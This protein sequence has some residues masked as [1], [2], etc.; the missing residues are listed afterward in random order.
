M[1][2]AAAHGACPGPPRASEPAVTWAVCS[3]LVAVHIGQVLVLVRGASCARP[4]LLQEL[5]GSETECLTGHGLPLDTAVWVSDCRAL[6]V[7]ALF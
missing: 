2:I 1:F 6:L 7:G 5:R 4:S 3:R